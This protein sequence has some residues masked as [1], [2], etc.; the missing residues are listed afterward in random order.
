MV[1]CKRTVKF[2]G[3][4]ILVVSAI[5]ASGCVGY[6]KI[7]DI[8]KEPSKYEDKNISVRGSISEVAS[9]P[10]IKEG[11]YEIDDGTDSIWVITQAGTPEKGKTYSVKGTVKIVKMFPLFGGDQ[12]VIYEIER[13]S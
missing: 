10:G 1:F 13:R 8:Q 5:L 4:A 7:D 3:F 9:I 11:F 12:A 6:V 2:L